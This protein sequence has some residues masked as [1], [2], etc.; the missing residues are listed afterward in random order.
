MPAG[1]DHTLIRIL[2]GCFFNSLLLARIAVLFEPVSRASMSR[3]KDAFGWQ[4]ARNAHHRL[5]EVGGPFV[6][7]IETLQTGKITRE[8]GRLKQVKSQLA[9]QH[10]YFEVMPTN[11]GTR[12]CLPSASDSHHHGSSALPVCPARF[13][14]RGI[15][16]L[17]H[18]QNSRPHLG[19]FHWRVCL[20][21]GRKSSQVRLHAGPKVDT[22]GQVEVV[23][24][25]D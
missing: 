13:N 16:S 3:N 9:I 1:V 4:N 6:P 10:K 8:K 12:V 15:F 2:V 11:F 24:M 18:K 22:L 19:G 14:S 20:L 7:Q 21:S 17:T 23:Q 25:E 5:D